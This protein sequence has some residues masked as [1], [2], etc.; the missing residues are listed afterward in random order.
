MG[1]IVIAVYQPKPGKS[2]QLLAL[3]KDHLPILRR[4]GL[5]TD[6]EGIAALSA[7]GSIIEMFEWVSN[8][9]I[10]TAHGHPEVLAMW[11]RYAEVCEYVPYSSL[12]EAADLF[13]N[14]DPL[15][16]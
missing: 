9:A 1:R 11:E 13:P 12:P 14:F 8:E 5:V 16:L 7:D 3:A 4:L 2:E 10:E 15:D 6:R